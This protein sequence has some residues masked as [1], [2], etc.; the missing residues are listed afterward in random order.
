M[1]LKPTSL[2]KL[3]KKTT[4]EISELRQENSTLKEVNGQLTNDLNDLK[5]QLEQLNL[6]KTA[7]TPTTPPPPDEPKP[8]QMPELHAEPTST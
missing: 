6:T 5:S 3:L 7:A 4:T 8:L 1:R 2:R